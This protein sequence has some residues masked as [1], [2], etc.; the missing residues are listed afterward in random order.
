MTTRTRPLVELDNLY[1]L[2]GGSSEGAS[3][4]RP[5]HRGTAAA[6]L[7]GLTLHI[8]GGERIVVRGPSG[9]GKSTL[10]SVITAELAASAGSAVVLGRDTSRL[11]AR[12]VRVLQRTG[13]GLVSQRT[14]LDLFPELDCVANVAL[15][16]RLAGRSA[17]EAATA[18]MEML[19]R[20][21]VAELAN[22]R[23]SVLSG[24][25]RQRVALA[26]ALAHGPKIVVLDEPT[27][28]LDA[29][30]AA[31]IYRILRD[32]GTET[33]SALVLVTHDLEADRIATRVLTIDDGRVSTE[34]RPATGTGEVADHRSDD[35]A[36]LVVDSQGWV[37]LPRH[38]RSLAGIGALVRSEPA[39][40]AITLVN[41][42]TGPETPVPVEVPRYAGQP[43]AAVSC[44]DLVVPLGEGRTLG[45]IDFEAHAGQLVVLTGR[46][47][48]GKTSILSALLGQ[49]TPLSGK[50]QVFTADRI[51]CMPQA[52]AFSER[53]SVGENLAL[54]TV[55]RGEPKTDPEPVLAALA[56][57]G[58]LDR[59]VSELSGGER[60]RVAL[61]RVLTSLASLILVDEPTSQL[62]RRLAAQV[63]AALQNAT[64]AGRTVICATHDELLIEAAD[65]VVALDAIQASD[66]PSAPLRSSSGFVDG[67]GITGS[68]TVQEGQRPHHGGGDET[69]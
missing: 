15:Q 1:V 20:F 13:M 18:A 68:A 63:V 29:Q 28:E 21:G 14:G 66:L 5:R 57:T 27:G 36:S 33:D 54:A 11:S 12:E 40:G 43:M 25:E 46:S 62:D 45:P 30:N 2:R 65:I 44:S 8:H 32:L 52:T 10:V 3:R 48:S 47:G 34:R 4:S 58:F 31:G 35:V 53:Q 51:S 26:A 59:R 41:Q 55:I 42:D 50:L 17:R 6:A 69:L 56:L 60:Q 49:R 39:P 22:A 24:G 16:S 19:E 67:A 38:D 23:P 37:W 9:S 7:R 64:A 61:A